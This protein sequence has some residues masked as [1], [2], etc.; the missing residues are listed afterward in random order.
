MQDDTQNSQ[1]N[2][3]TNQN[4]N[5]D[6]NAEQN[7]Q[8][9]QGESTGTQQAGEATQDDKPKGFTNRV[10]YRYPEWDE[11]NYYRL[12]DNKLIVSPVMDGSES[13][14]RDRNNEQEVDPSRMDAKLY[15]NIVARLHSE[16][17][18]QEWGV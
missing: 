18:A 9:D 1:Q 8:G 15:D 6:S 4:Q 12:E 7:Q 11:K 10:F 16:H 2:A 13:D 14:E 3:D 5:A 17:E